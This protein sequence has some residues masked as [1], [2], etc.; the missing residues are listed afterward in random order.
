MSKNAVSQWDTTAGNNTDVGGISIAE[1]M[2]PGNVNN[3]MREMMAQLAVFSAGLRTVPVGAIL[4]WS[5]S[6]AS[7]PSGWALCDGTSG[8]P[9]LRDRFIVGAGSSYAVGATGG[10]NQVT[11]AYGE[12]PAHAHTFSAT[13]STNGDHS[14]GAVP[15]FINDNDRG[16]GNASLFSLDNAGQT[17]IAGAHS[18]T[19]SGSTSVEGSSA[20]HENRPPFFALAYIMRTV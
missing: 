19:V 13:T 18:H 3:A 11:L 20:A 8:T 12:M 5:G 15:Q 7:I 16:V 10:Q 2:A 17:T 1:G 14:H 9:D 4:M 6:I